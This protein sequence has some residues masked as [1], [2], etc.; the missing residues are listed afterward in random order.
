MSNKCVDLVSD[1]IEFNIGVNPKR[2][3]QIDNWPLFIRQISVLFIGLLFRLFLVMHWK[4]FS[5][6][7]F[8]LEWMRCIRWIISKQ[9]EFLRFTYTSKEE[10]LQFFVVFHSKKCLESGAAFAFGICA[11]C[12]R[13]HSIN[14]RNSIFIIDRLCF[15]SIY[16][17]M[18]NIH[19]KWRKKH[20]FFFRFNKSEF[21]FPILL[22]FF[23]VFLFFGYI[24]QWNFSWFFLII[25][26]NLLYLQWFCS[27]HSSIYNYIYIYMHWLYRSSFSGCCF[28]LYL[29]LLSLF[30]NNIFDIHIIYV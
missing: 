10:T 25:A 4:H 29:L 15:Q 2:I 3:H 23:F 14:Q 9:A 16:S 19:G 30:M 26:F 8:F 28:F 17:L 13:L 7:F 11:M 27:L 21:Y 22:W 20:D 18:L 12:G 5:C 1:F 6:C 24:F